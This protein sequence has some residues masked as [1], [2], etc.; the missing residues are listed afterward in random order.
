MK[1]AKKLVLAAVVLPLTLGTA[2]AFAFGGKDH[3]GH[4]GECGMGMDRGI[5]RQLDLTD[6]Q[7]DQLKEMREANKAEM[8]AKFADGKEARMAERQ[9]HHDKVQALLLAD[10]FDAAAANDLA[11]EMVEK[12]TE[13]RVK[14][15]EKKHQML[16]VLTPE[17][18][19]KF[20]EL[21]KERQQ[22]CGEKMQKRMEKHHNS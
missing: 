6:A 21:Q 11:K 4:R 13:R 15:M 7:K 12:Q 22:K 3:K 1:T 8:K 16:S 17:Q 10:N 18:K 2:S 14:M 9:A 20:V 5:M 19:T